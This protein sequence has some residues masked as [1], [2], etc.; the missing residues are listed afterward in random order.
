MRQI[1][2]VM[3]NCGN[4]K[5]LDIITDDVASTARYSS[6]TKQPNSFMTRN[7]GP[8]GLSMIGGLIIANG[9]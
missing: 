8:E 6:I 2:H 1:E 5:R 4:W 9:A 3:G 7:N